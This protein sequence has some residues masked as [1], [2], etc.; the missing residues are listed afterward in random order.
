MPSEIRVDT[1][2]NTSGLGTITYNSDGTTFSGMVTSRGPINVTTV[3][4]Y[5]NNQTVASAYTITG[6]TNAF[7]AGPVAINT[8]ITVTVNTGGYWKII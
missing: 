4:F 6:T 1:G 3:P 5:Q 2:K 7:T 8:S